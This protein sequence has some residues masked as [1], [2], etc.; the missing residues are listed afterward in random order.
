MS[1][2]ESLLDDINALKNKKPP[3]D[4]DA[5]RLRSLLRQVNELTGAAGSPAPAATKPIGDV[6]AGSHGSATLAGGQGGDDLNGPTAGEEKKWLPSPSD[7]GVNHLAK[8]RREALDSGDQGRIDGANNALSHYSPDDQKRIGEAAGLMVKRGRK[9][10]VVL[11]IPRRA[12]DGHAGPIDPRRLTGEQVYDAIRM[13]RD[14]SAFVKG[15]W[16]ERMEG[17]LAALAELEKSDPDKAAAIWQKV[18]TL[19]EERDDWHARWDY[20]KSVLPATV[21]DGFLRDASRYRQMTPEERNDF[22]R[23]FR[24]YERQDPKFHEAIWGAI[25]YEA[26]GEEI[27]AGPKFLTMKELEERIKKRKDLQDI[28]GK[29]LDVAI[30]PRKP[31]SP[32]AL[33]AALLAAGVYTYAW[34]SGKN[35]QTD[36]DRRLQ[37]QAKP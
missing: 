35:A 11:T 24:P 4:D 5:P 31:P 13:P 2:W 34:K 3:S 12:D 20:I 14:S 23:R 22:A 9:G 32:Y 8:A 19:H 36:V 15:D 18:R 25:R 17:T 7:G 28:A 10:E 6:A 37:V 16:K 21:R 1:L 30:D 29:V 27:K 33:L 26:V